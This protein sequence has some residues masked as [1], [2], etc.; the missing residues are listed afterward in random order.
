MSRRFREAAGKAVDYVY[1][2]R[3]RERNGASQPARPAIHRRQL[4]TQGYQ[5]RVHESMNIESASASDA[6]LLLFS[7]S[8]LRIVAVFIEATFCALIKFFASPPGIPPFPE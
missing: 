1:E 8:L 5:P 4:N 2:A 6:S 3:C 7:S